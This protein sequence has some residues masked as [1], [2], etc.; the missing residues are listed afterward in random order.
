M[1]YDGEQDSDTSNIRTNFNKTNTIQVHQNLQNIQSQKKGIKK[2]PVTKR[3]LS[4]IIEEEAGY[5][6]SNEESVVDEEKSEEGSQEES[7]QES[8]TSK[9]S[10][11][12][13]SKS[14][15]EENKVEEPID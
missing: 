14:K 5:H 6:P 12:E 15:H 2:T 3:E 10:D 7:K 8:E 11:E 1:S 13:E 4:V 9:T